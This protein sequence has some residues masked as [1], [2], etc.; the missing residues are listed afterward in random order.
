MVIR[1]TKKNK[2][3]KGYMESGCV[4][5]ELCCNFKYRSNKMSNLVGDI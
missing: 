2:T 1:T 3:E 5:G 4:R